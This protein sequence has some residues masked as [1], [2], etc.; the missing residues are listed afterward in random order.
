MRRYLYAILALAALAFHVVHTPPLPEPDRLL[1][2]ADGSRLPLAAALG[3]LFSAR[4]VFVGELHDQPA[5][6]RAQ[7][8]VLQAFHE[9]DRPV[10]LGLEMFRA[11]SQPALDRWAAG[12]LPLGEFLRV[13]YD[14]W[15]LPWAFYADLLEYARDHRIPVLGLNVDPEVI[16]QV[17]QTGFSSLTPR[18]VG[19][20]PQVRCE[21]DEAYEGFIRQALGMGG[22]SGRAFR[23]FCEAQ[24]VWDTAMASNL[25]RFA[26]ANP[27]YTVVVLAGS[28]HAWKRGIPAQ[29]GRL[30]P[31]PLRVLVPELP[32]RLERRAATA[33]D[34]DYLWLGLPLR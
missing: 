22:H 21:V 28:G 27:S 19:E 6:H 8:R 11:E 4:L 9:A 5:H 18:Q 14:N 30:G 15:N 24:L 34:A 7:L 12:E 33:A 23:N 20:L 25:L 10:A 16:R 17:A 2:L 3:D 26:Q 32:G 29:V 1:R 31:L 13:Y